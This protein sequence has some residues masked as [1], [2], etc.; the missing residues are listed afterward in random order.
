MVNSRHKGHARARRQF[1]D[2]AGFHSHRLMVDLHGEFPPA[3]F[4]RD[5]S[6]DLDGKASPAA[7]DVLLFLAM[8]VGRCGHA[9]LRIHE[10]F[11]VFRFLGEVHQNQT[12]IPPI[13]ETK[14]G[15]IPARAWGR[16]QSWASKQDWADRM[17][18]LISLRFIRSFCRGKLDRVS[19]ELDV[20][21]ARQVSP[22]ADRE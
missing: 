10:F 3:A 9:L 15:D 8:A 21:L 12:E 18:V 20:L 7:N 22:P 1:D 13:R 17:R 11:A 4:T 19:Q 6:P 16:A 14:I 2:L 5:T